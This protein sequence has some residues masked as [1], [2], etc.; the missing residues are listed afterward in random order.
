MNP[1]GV[2]NMAYSNQ[3]NRN[4]RGNSSGYSKGN[5]ANTGRQ[6]KNA[7]ADVKPTFK[8]IIGPIIVNVAESDNTWE[9]ALVESKS[10]DKP[11]VIFTS[12]ARCYKDQEGKKK[13]KQTLTIP[14]KLLTLD[15]KMEMIFSFAN[16]LEIDLEEELGLNKGQQL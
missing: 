6:D 8:N 16:S 13:L 2:N 14:S 1:R 10:G 3:G 4:F 9:F 11:A 15:E 12:V 7:N 5:E